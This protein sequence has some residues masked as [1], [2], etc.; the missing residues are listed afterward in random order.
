MTIKNFKLDAKVKSII[1]RTERELGDVYKE[2][3]RNMEY[4]RE[5]KCP[6]CEGSGEVGDNAG[7]PNDWLKC[8][9]CNGDGKYSPFRNATPR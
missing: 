3:M 5:G 7:G 9:D 6:T 8:D 2:H 4:M 1:E